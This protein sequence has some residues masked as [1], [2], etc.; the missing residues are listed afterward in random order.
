MQLWNYLL[1]KAYYKGEI[2]FSQHFTILS[3]QIISEKLLHIV[4]GG[5]K[6]NFNN[7]FKLELITI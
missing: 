5:Q 3:Q 7:K 2:L 4:T 6:I 1:Y